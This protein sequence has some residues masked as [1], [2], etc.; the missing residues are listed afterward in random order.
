MSAI[1]SAAR[2]SHRGGTR[3]VAWGDPMRERTF[4]TVVERVAKKADLGHLAP[5]DL[6]RSA[7]GI[8]HNELSDDGGH[9]YDLLDIQQVLDHADPATT[10]R[11]YLNP[12]GSDAKKRAGSS[13][14]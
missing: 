2:P 3:R 12:M 4:S 14:D 6:R 9:R 5:H 7:A 8:L 11:S 1:R 13:L 10:Q